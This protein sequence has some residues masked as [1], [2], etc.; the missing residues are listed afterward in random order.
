MTDSLFAA[1]AIAASGLAAQ[2]ARMRIVSENI[3][4]AESTGPTTGS[5]P[6][7][8]KI[9]S[10]HAAFDRA[11]GIETVDIDRIGVDKSPFRVERDP[12][13]PAADAA[14]HVKYPNVST[15]I[16][17]ADMREA[18]RAYEANL[19]ILKQA[20]EITNMQIDL[21]RTSS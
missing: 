12:G 2:S 20:R 6:Y 5:D 8:R 16:E 11:K 3:A 4:N 19:Q 21:L 18:S 7:Q 15:L 17:L 10:F 14:G 13:H 9:I 1:S